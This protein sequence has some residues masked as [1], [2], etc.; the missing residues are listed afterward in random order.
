[1]KLIEASKHT[2]QSI[3]TVLSNA[4]YYTIVLQVLLIE[5]WF[6]DHQH[7]HWHALRTCEECQLDNFYSTR[8]CM[9]ARSPTDGEHVLKLWLGE[10]NLQIN[11]F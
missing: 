3:I 9:L 5:V 4:S 1:M 11:Y 6:K 7:Q 10:P 8:I 2:P